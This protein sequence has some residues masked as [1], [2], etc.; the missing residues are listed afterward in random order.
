M[1]EKLRAYLQEVLRANQQFNLTAVRDENLAWSKH[2]VDSLQGLESSLFE[3]E[4]K[5]IDVGTGPGFPGV[6]L[7]I[8]KPQLQVTLLESIR[9]KC[10]FLEAATAHHAPNAKVLCGR[11]EELGHDRK[12]RGQ[13]DVAV[14][15]AVGS[16]SEVLE[17]CLP[18]VRLG[19]SALL[20][21]GQNA[22]DEIIAA[23]QALYGLGGQAEVFF[24][25]RLPDH[26]SEYHLVRVKKVRGTPR[27]YPRRAGLPKKQPLSTKLM[28][29]EA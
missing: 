29:P 23:K 4:A 2:V 1:E 12:L 6:V 5:V 7:A 8:A 26:D 21:R 3:G 19:G 9:K 10:N 18:F 13:F 11:A 15:R 16:L 25:Y 28:E 24:S 14:A 17:L 27:G 22:H 20:W